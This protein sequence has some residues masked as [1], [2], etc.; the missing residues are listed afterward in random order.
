M[1]FPK[2]PEYKD[3]GIEWLGEAPA[4]GCRDLVQIRLNLI[5]L[6]QSVDPVTL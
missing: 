5:G 1:S 2:Y 6:N 4:T 3:S